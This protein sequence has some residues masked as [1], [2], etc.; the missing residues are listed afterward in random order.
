VSIAL[1]AYILPGV[2]GALVG[3]EPDVSDVQERDSESDGRRAGG[4][5][6]G[7]GVLSVSILSGRSF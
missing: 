7:L 6:N 5:N 1:W 3:D 2:L 4:S